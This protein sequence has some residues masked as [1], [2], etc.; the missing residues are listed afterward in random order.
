MASKKKKGS[1]GVML[2]VPIVLA[3]FFF[4]IYIGG[5]IVHTHPSME[6][7]GVGAGFVADSHASPEELQAQAD[8]L[9]E[10]A[11]LAASEQAGGS[12]ML[13]GAAAAVH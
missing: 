9:H 8:A 3:V 12:P 10:A 7:A 4:G 2:L 1:V 13:R 11:L 6:T 5:S